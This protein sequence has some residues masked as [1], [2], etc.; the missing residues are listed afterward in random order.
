MLDGKPFE[1]ENYEVCSATLSQENTNMLN[2][3]EEDG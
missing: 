1:F 3:I 2:L